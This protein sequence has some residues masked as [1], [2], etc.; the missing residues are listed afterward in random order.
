MTQFT[1]AV[2]ENGRLIPLQPLEGIPEHSVVRILVQ[3]G[4]PLDAAK[5]H[6]MLQAVPY[7]PELADTVEAGRNQEWKIEEF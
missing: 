5:Q 3:L 6:E 1:T 4:A 2:Y 7:A